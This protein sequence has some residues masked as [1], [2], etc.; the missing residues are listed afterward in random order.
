MSKRETKPAEP[1]S[2]E[3]SRFERFLS[4]LFRVDKRDVP[5]HEPKRRVQPGR[6]SER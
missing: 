4:A 1:E 6:P 2:E 5:K 3:Y